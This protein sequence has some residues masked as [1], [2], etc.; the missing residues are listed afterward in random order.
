MCPS[1]L[2]LG[3]GKDRVRP[4]EGQRS[5]RLAGAGQLAQPL[6][7]IFGAAGPRCWNIAC[8]AFDCMTTMARGLAFC[9]LAAAGCQSAGAKEGPKGGAKEGLKEGL[10]EGATESS[11]E[12]P[13]PVPG[14]SERFEH[15]M[16][17]RFHMHQSFD[18]VRAIEKLIVRGNLE[19]ARAFARAI[20]EA[21]DEPGLGPWAPHAALVRE[22]AGELAHAASVE[23]ACRRQARL[24]EACAGCHLDAGVAPE[25][26]PPR[27]PPD[28][29]T[30]DARMARH[31]WATGRMWEGLVGAEDGAW[32]EGLD[33]LAVT[34]LPA[35]QA[36][37]ADLARRLQQLAG[38][39]RQRARTDTLAERA[40]AYGEMLVTCAGCHTSRPAEHAGP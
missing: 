30:L 32:R 38:D 15:D 12:A 3:R 39:A 29:P 5:A 16:M 8:S 19:D 20:A 23:D 18:L 36:A 10:K 27:A 17:V 1:Q 14:P 2:G 25:L 34:P 26:R 40:R 28:Q 6:R 24:A 11:K 13:R 33:V 22:R 35:A 4:G 9:L 7:E 31:R 21:P 37:R